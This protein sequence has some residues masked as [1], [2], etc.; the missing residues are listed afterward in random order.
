MYG[1]PLSHMCNMHACLHNHIGT[2]HTYT[3][4]FTST[5][6][7][8]HAHIKTCQNIY[9]HAETHIDIH[10]STYMNTGVHRCTRAL[11]LVSSAYKRAARTHVCSQLHL[12]RQWLG[13]KLSLTLPANKD[14]GLCQLLEVCPGWCFCHLKQT[15]VIWEEETSEEKMAQLA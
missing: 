10:T 6:V 3:L 2:V 8:I 1:C 7:H 12:L 15:I 14:P 13:E 4:K 9:I 5:Q 11:F